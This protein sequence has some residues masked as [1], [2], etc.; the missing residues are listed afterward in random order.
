MQSSVQSSPVRKRRSA[1]AGLC[2]TGGFSLL[3]LMLVLA[4]IGVLM[5]VAAY[6]VLGGGARA[7]IT[8][9]KASLTT[10]KTALT[11]Y[12][13]DQS[14]FPPDLH[15]LVTT[16]HLDDKAL[17]DGWKNAFNYDPRGRDADHPFIL[18]S[19]GP[20]GQVGTADDID[21]WTMDAPTTP[22]APQ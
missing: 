2:H 6:N 7:K 8:A 16:K 3:E 22:T 12:N 11:A 9:T 15:T 18:F 21:V 4:I 19:N 20:D 10:I 5:A 17:G 14:A 1:G 13:L